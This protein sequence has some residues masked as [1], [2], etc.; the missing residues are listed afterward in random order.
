MGPSVRRLYEQGKDVNGAGINCSFAVHQDATG[1][2]AD[3]AVGWAIA[4]GAPFAFGAPA[5]LASKGHGK[6]QGVVRVRGSIR[7][8]TRHS[9]GLRAGADL[10]LGFR[11]CELGT[12]LRSLNTTAVANALSTLALMHCNP[13]RP[14]VCAVGS[15]ITASRSC[16]GTTLESEYKSDIYGER[17]I[18]L[19]GVHG[20]VEALFKRY[21]REG[22]RCGSYSHVRPI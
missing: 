12:G 21:T 5:W 17:A 22:M 8:R 10:G 1:G 13:T 18:L 19:G 6:E 7:V 2:A 16:A 3:I 15:A 9:S 11:P 14:C 20:M 4:I